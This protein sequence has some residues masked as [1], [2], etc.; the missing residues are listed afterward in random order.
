MKNQDDTR[1]PLR[2]G[3]LG[4]YNWE[5]TLDRPRTCWWD[6]ISHLAWE[7]LGVPQ[8]EREDVAGEKD[9]LQPRPR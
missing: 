3:T 8:E 6:Y 5:E 4:I 1:A 2:G 9:A 7:Y